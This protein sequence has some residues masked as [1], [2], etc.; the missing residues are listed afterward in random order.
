[1]LFRSAETLVHMLEDNGILVGNGS[2]CSSKK[3]DNRNLR[4]MGYSD[5]EIEGAIRISFSEFN[6]LDEVKT[7][8]EKLNESVKEYLQ[9]V[10]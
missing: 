6:T 3:K 1:M 2:A 7:L 5:R 9:K 8:V 4:E 10:R